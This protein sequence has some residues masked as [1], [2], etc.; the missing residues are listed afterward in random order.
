[1]MVSTRVLLSSPYFW[2]VLTLLAAVAI[3]AGSAWLLNCCYK[4]ILPE[5]YS[6]LKYKFGAPLKSMDI[7][8]KLVPLPE[9]VSFWGN[10]YIHLTAPATGKVDIYEDIIVFSAQN[11]ALVINKNDP[12]FTKKVYMDPPFVTVSDFMGELPLNG[13]SVGLEIV[14]TDELNELIKNIMGD[15]HN[16]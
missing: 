11:N 2:G 7:M 5:D 16:V 13:V 3:I 10:C 12:D 15:N 1:M 4:L 14:L 8:I 6:A 9:P